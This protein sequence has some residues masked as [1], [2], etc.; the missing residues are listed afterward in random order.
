MATRTYRRGRLGK[1][2][3]MLLGAALLLAGPAGC[4]GIRNAGE[5]V[6]GSRSAAEELDPLADSVR[7]SL[8]PDSVRASIYGDEDRPRLAKPHAHDRGRDWKKS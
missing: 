5:D 8:Y 1:R 7:A 6:G 3:L 2:L 4:G